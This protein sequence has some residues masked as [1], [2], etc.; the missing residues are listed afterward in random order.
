MQIEIEELE[1]AAH[2]LFKH[3]KDNNIN[4]IDLSEDYYWDFSPSVRYDTAQ[5]PGETDRE[6]GQLFDDLKDIY[7]VASG[8]QPPINYGFVWLAAILRFIGEKVKE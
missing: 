6:A 7:S 3:L 8:E 5:T 4:S 1:K 2:I